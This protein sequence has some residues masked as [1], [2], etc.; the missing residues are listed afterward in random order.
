MISFRYKGTEFRIY[1]SFLL[2]NSLL[3]LTEAR[4]RAAGFY[5]AAAVH[6]T[7][8]ILTA[9]AFGQRLLAV[10]FR[11]TGIVMEPEKNAAAPLRYG[12]AVLLSGPA[13]N[14]LLWWLLKIAGTYEGTAEISLMLCLYNILPYR[15]LDGGALLSLTA[16][17]RVHEREIETALL[18]VK[19]TISAVL[20]FAVFSDRAAFIP[21]AVSVLLLLGDIY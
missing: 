6:E 4:G 1:F 2:F 3:F 20:F 12:A 7:A 15:Q 14:L 10:D 9:A 21:F 18:L 11:G 13:A 5:A 19:I 17:G 16:C 8:H